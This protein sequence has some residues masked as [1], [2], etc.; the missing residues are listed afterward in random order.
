MGRYSVPL[1]PQLADL[2]GCRGRAAGAR[3]RLRARRP[4][5]RAGRA[6]R[7]RGRLGGRPVGAASSPPLGRV[8]RAST[9][10]GLRPSSC[11]FE[12]GTFDAALAQLVVHFMADPVGGLAEM[13]RVT[14]GGGVVAACVWDHAGGHGPLSPFW[15]AAH[16]LDPEA[17]GRVAARRA[18][19]RA[20]SPSSSSRRASRELEDTALCR[21][22]SSTRPSRSGGSRSRS[23]SARPARMRPGSIRNARAPC[24]S[25]AVSCSR[26]PRSRSRREPGPCA[27]SPRRGPANRRPRSRPPSAP[28]R[29]HASEWC[30][31]SRRCG[32]EHRASEPRL[33]RA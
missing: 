23:A 10:S 17:E 7:R 31:C 25:A 2:A 8:T 22:P 16:E 18:P 9:S 1:A 6:A 27:A 13:R 4:H 29:A 24:A 11:P 32:S 14:R 21:S 20:T 15:Q 19:A 3:R 30:R 26:P 28:R 12:D 5:R 33:R